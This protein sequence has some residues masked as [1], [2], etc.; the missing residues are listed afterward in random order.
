MTQ[1]ENLF[2][3]YANRIAGADTLKLV[4]EYL[5]SF[6]IETIY[7]S[8]FKDEMEREISNDQ[9]FNKGSN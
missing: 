4:K 7:D 6:F 8:E 9:D 3:F 1:R 2:D 5:A